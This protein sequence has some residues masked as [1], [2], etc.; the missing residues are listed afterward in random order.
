MTR[1]ALAITLALALAACGDNLQLP[2]AAPP[3]PACRAVFAGDFAETDDTA[4]PCASLE[5]GPDGAWSL[6]LTVPSTALGDPLAV[7]IELAGQP[8]TG[9]SSSGGATAWSAFAF[10]RVGEGGCAYRAGSAASPPGSFTLALTTVDTAAH[11][12]HGTLQLSMR[13]LTTPGTAC[14]DPDTETLALS[15]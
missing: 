14:G 4:T 10:Q 15:F 13:V 2:D 8:T 5:P 12:A 1:A 7:A 6:A 9:T 3:G 11:S